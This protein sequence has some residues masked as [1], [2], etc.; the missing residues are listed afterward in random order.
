VVSAHAG[1]GG[2][3]QRTDRKTNSGEGAKSAFEEMKRRARASPNPPA[4]IQA[5]RDRSNR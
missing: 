2:E 5:K 3:K 4:P 1:R